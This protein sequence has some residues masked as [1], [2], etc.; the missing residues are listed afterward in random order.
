MFC[1]KPVHDTQGLKFP[2]WFS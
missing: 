1:V 2:Q